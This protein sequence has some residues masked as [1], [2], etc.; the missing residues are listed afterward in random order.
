MTMDRSFNPH[1]IEQAQYEAWEQAKHFAPNGNGEGY[2]IL[3]PPPN[4]TGTLHM[5][6]AFNQTLMDTLIRYQRMKGRRTLWQMGTDHAG[7]ATQ[8][9]VERQLADEGID[10]KELGREAFVERVWDWRENSGGTIAHQIR[11]MGSSLDWSRDRF[12]MD[13]AYTE[14]VLT[15]FEHLFDEGL[16]YKGQRLVNWDPALATAISD[17]EV[18]NEEENGSLWHFHYPLENGRT[19][20]DGNAYLSVATTRPETMLGDTAVAVHPDDKR[21]LHLVGGEVMLPLANRTIPI[22]A[23]EYV[24]M[25]FGTGCVKITPA[26]DF[27]DNEVASR[28]SLPLINIFNPDATINANAPEKYR[29]L[30]REEARHAVITDLD[31]QGYLGEIKDHKLM[32]PRGDRSGAIIEPLLTDQW[33][34]KIKPLAGP[35][36][37]AVENGDIE[38]VPKQYENLYFSW[39]HDIQDWCISR[40]QWWGH[41]IP[42]YYDSDGNV[43]VGANENAVRTK[44]GLTDQL[45]LTQETD[46]LETWFSSALWPFATL[47]WPKE[48]PELEKFLPS[49]TLITG[50]DIIFFW[51]A[52]MIMMTLHFTGKIPF[53]KVYIHGLVKDAAGQKM[54]KTKGNGLDPLDFIDGISLDDL[55]AKRTSNLTQP[56]LVPGIEKATRKD[57]P[58]GIP[59]YGTDALRFTFCALATTGRDVRFDLNRIDGYRNFCNKIWNAAKFVLTNTEDF[60]PSLNAS[61]STIDLWISSKFSRAVEDCELALDTYRFDMF[62]NAIYE[63]AWHEYCDWYLELIKPRLWDEHLSPEERSGSQRT[64]LEILESL[65]RLAHP[66]MPFITETIWQQIVPRISGDHETI[67]T[68]SYPAAVDFTS[69][70]GAEREVDWLKAVITCIRTIRGEANIKPSQT[71]DIVFQ[72]GRAEDVVM[73]NASNAMLERLANVSSTTWLDADEE[74]PPNA[75]ALVGDLKVMIPLAGLIDVVAELGR[76]EKDIEK[77]QADLQKVEGKLNNGNFVSKAPE[78]VVAKEREKASALQARI[79]AL[80]QQAD[81]LN[82]TA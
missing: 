7:I 38:F 5:G 79:S 61:R 76:I 42:A 30:S 43:Y 69:D 51:V 34:V 52:R 32:V 71:V 6:H 2:C 59:G 57:F 70:A 64:L 62:A 19:T 22:I 53:Q 81:K 23:D 65:L 55:I 58:A 1:A 40:Q 26:H 18:E 47:G 75:L 4:V 60:D 45:A 13:P 54:S 20:Q 29:G 15:V 8:M 74:P 36:I 50:H 12:T 82:R 39:M 63:F 10:R 33:F 46:V 3:I 72:G 37:A 41:R 24:D 66:V 31:A 11:R 49:N 25:A 77:A 17:L 73:A 28:H 67:M 27:N 16:I 14:A 80:H 48:T 44:Y 56:Q 35:A 78:E 21:Y 9:L 68:Q